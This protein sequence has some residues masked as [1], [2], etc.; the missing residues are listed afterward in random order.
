MDVTVQEVSM[1]ASVAKD[2]SD[3]MSVKLPALAAP[4]LM[5]VFLSFFCEET[6]LFGDVD[7]LLGDLTALFSEI[8]A[9]SSD[10]ADCGDVRGDVTTSI[11]S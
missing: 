6:S 10:S 9:I 11:C 2:L 3:E 8:V 7:S 5:S 1:T 4:S